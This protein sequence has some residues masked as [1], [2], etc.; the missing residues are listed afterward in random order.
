VYKGKPFGAGG[1]VRDQKPQEELDRL[2]MS[3]R[4]SSLAPER[5][6]TFS[7]KNVKSVSSPDFTAHLLRQ[8]EP[9]G[10][11]SNA[12]GI[13]SGTYI[14]FNASF[15]STMSPLKPVAE[16]DHDFTRQTSNCSSNSSKQPKRRINKAHKPDSFLNTT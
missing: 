16:N 10:R 5:R 13:A 11:A 9:A 14:D 12:V 4:I 6:K 2:M 1:V 15:P 8:V 7:M 3:K